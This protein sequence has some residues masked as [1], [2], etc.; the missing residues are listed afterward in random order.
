VTRAE[1]SIGLAST[2]AEEIAQTSTR[3]GR[4]THR[5]AGCKR[6]FKV[7]E[8]AAAWPAA[9]AAAATPAAKKQKRA[10]K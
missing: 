4:M 9:R 10:S 2:R 8:Y 6:K 1:R 7:A 5:H 3:A